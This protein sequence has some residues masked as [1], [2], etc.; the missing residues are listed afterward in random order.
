MQMLSFS[1]WA[2]ADMFGV[3]FGAARVENAGGS[4][5][6]PCYPRYL[7]NMQVGPVAYPEGYVI[8]GKDRHGNYWGGGCR[9]Q[10]R[11]DKLGAEFAQMT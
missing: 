7:Q 6:S 3:D 10:G 2:Q 8:I 11:W 4:N 1:N 9:V 5:A